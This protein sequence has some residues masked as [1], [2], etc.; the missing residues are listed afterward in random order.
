[1]LVSSDIIESLFGKFKLL[2]ARNPKAEFN[3]I[4]LSIVTLCGITTPEGI[5]SALDQV[6]Q[7]DLDTWTKE[8]VKVSQCQLRHAFNQ[9]KLRPDMVPKSGKIIFAESG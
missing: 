3:R 2:V 6:K 9:G 1:L 5:T 8:N 4:V 7:S